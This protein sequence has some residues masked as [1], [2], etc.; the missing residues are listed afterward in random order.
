MTR[1]LPLLLLATSLTAAP[2]KSILGET[3]SPGKGGSISMPMQ[4]LLLL[5]ALTLLP[6]IVMSITPFLR[7]TIVL[8]F[9]RQALGTQS[10]PS[11]QVLI[12]LS[13]FLTILIMN[14]VA[15][16]IYHKGWEPMEKNQLNY[17]Q[18]FDAGSKPLTSC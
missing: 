7:I 18:A 14:P 2:L 12:G 3:L 16:E 6:A 15:S 13:M 17:E 9:L 1:L 8:H 5:T 4:I 10:T 11:N